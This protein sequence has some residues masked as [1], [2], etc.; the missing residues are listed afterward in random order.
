MREDEIANLILAID[1]R[2]YLTFF[3][4]CR[5]TQWTYLHLRWAFT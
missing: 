3:F 2:I 4:K 5:I 1:K